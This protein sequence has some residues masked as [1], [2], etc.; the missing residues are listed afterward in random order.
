MSGMKIKVFN[1]NVGY[2]RFNSIAL[3]TDAEF[4]PDWFIENY[5]INRKLHVEKLVDKPLQ[6]ILKA[7][8]KRPPS[9]ESLVFEQE[10]Q[11]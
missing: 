6:N 1:L 4:V 7:V 3:P 2:E 8:D 10:W 11:F 5:V 9:K